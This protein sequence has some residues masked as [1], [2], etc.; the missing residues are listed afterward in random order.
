MLVGAYAMANIDAAVRFLIENEALHLGESPWNTYE[1]GEDVHQI[2]WEIMFPPSGRIRRDQEFDW[3]IEG[4]DWAP[5]TS[6]EFLSELLEGAARAKDRPLE[7][8]QSL[9]DTC[10]WYQPIHYFGYDWGIF[11]REDCVLRQALAISRF[12]DYA[13]TGNRV[14]PLLAKALIRASLYVYFLHEHFHHK[15]ECL[16]FRLHVVERQSAYI[17]YCIRIY[18]PTYGTDDNIEE[19]LANADAFLRLGNEP[20]RSW[21]GNTVLSATKSYLRACYPLNPPGYRQAV[22]YLSGLQFDDGENL[23]QGQMRETTVS[24]VQP[25]AEWD[26]AP[27]LTQSIL[28]IKSNICSVVKAGRI[29]LFKTVFPAPT[30]STRD[31]INLYR[32]SGYSV[33]PGGKGS[34]VKL[35]KPGAPTMI[36]PGNR[37]ELSPGVAKTALKL[38]GGYKLD[39][40]PLLLS[41]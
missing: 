37:R 30:C 33:V 34:H 10:A 40:L 14:M 13:P 25:R 17:P 26:L 28:N 41:A 36:L 23:L 27:R 11:I 24:P 4:D 9:F 35:S 15:V 7:K 12:L 22:N 19:A 32:K 1:E 29:P 31:M 20:Y 38:L 2:D 3:L 6:S 21:L 8:D 16:G 39:D 5:E 18:R